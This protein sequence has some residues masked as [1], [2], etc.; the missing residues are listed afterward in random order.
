MHFDEVF[1]PAYH[2]E[3]AQQQR[4]QQ[5]EDFI[6]GSQLIFGTD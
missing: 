6:H 3:A 5:K 2:S 4:A 1:D